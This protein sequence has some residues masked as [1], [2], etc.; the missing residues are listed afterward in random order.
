MALHARAGDELGEVAEALAVLQPHARTAARHDPPLPVAPEHGRRLAAARAA[1][2]RGAPAVRCRRARGRRRGSTGRRRRPWRRSAQPRRLPARGSRARSSSTVA[3]SQG[4]CP[5]SRRST[6]ASSVAIAPTRSPDA[7]C[8]RD[9]SGGRTGLQRRDVEVT[10]ARRQLGTCRRRGVQVTAGQLG[11][12]QHG[13]QFGGAQ[14]IV[15]DDPQAAAG[16]R[17]GELVV[18]TGEVQAGHG[19]QRLHRVVDAE[20]QRLRVEQPSL[21]DPQVAEGDVR[22]PAAHRHHRL[23]VGLRPNEQRLGLV[24]AA[25]LH[26]QRRRDAVAVAGQEH[27][28]HPGRGRSV[29]AAAAACAHEPARSKSAAK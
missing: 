28:A 7:A 17:P 2:R 15:A 13:E 1:S 4:S 22:V 10:G 29:R 6:V 24:P 23:E 11:V 21:A 9:A 5:V 27:L 3:R 25:E 14:T 16:C 12:D 18:T 8:T 19:E 26:Q 20:Q